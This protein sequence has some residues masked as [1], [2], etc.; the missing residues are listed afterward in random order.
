MSRVRMNPKVSLGC[1][2]YNSDEQLLRKSLDSVLAQTFEDFELIICDNSPDDATARVCMEYAERDERISYYHNEV[3]M[4]AYPNFWRTFQ[5]AGGKYLKWVADDDILDREYLAKCVN[6]LDNDPT[7]ALCYT[8]VTVV[9]EN[10]EVKDDQGA[11]I[12]VMHDS[13]VERMLAV[14]D[15]SWNAQGFYGLMRADVVRRLHPIS[16]E[17]ARLAD[18]LLMA[19]IAIYGKIQQIP[20]NLFTYTLHELDWTD[21]ESL[22]AT[23]YKMCFPNKPNQGI[24]F[25][26]LKFA[27][28]L[29][30]AVRYSPLP[31]ED[32]SKLYSVIPVMIQNRISGFWTQEIRRAVW[33]VLNQRVFHDWGQPMEEVDSAKQWQTIPGVYQ[34]HAGELLRR[35]EE[36][37]CVWP[38]FPEPGIHSARA[39]LLALLERIG[40][41]TAVLQIELAKHPDYEPAQQLLKNLQAA[42]VKSNSSE[43]Q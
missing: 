41:A 4:G 20:E 18:L 16:D 23:F 30:Q 11:R 26:N 19:E 31:L 39:V 6:V 5:I 40:E 34:F 1:A 33:L 10:G 27:Y 42:T 38:N 9:T 17:C 24:T 25:P 13:P 8:R 2:V 3:N 37:L 15:H 28:E 12:E 21:R 36:V 14:L 35:F 29:L 32:K 7:V 22:N 43:Q